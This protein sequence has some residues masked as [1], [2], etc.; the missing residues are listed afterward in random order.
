L[1]DGLK[2]LREA[3][4]DVVL[5]NPQYA[6]KVIA[7]PD[8]ERMITLIDATAKETNVDVFERFAVMRHWRQTENR[9]FSLFISKDELHMNDWSYG[10]LAKLLAKSIAE[11]ATRPTLTATARPQR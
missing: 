1:R 4:P 8:V 7:K 10:C 6:P 2:R 9:P 3:G 5:I 11:A